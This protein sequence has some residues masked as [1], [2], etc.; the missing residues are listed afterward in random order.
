M[1]KLLQ[2]LFVFLFIAFSAMAQDRTITGTVTSQEDGL[3]LP[4]VS[5]KALGSAGGT[6]TDGNG[7]YSIKVSSANSLQF[8]YLGHVSKTLSIPSSGLLNLSLVPDANT[9]QDINIVQVAYGTQR[10]QDVVGSL[11]TVSASQLQKQQVTSVTQGLQGLATGVLVINGSGQPGTNPTIRIRGVASVNASAEPLIVLDGLA[12]SGSINSIGPNDVESMTVLKDAAATSLYGSRAANGVILITTKRGKNGDAA[13]NAY[14]NYGVSSRAVDEY[15]YVSSEDY[16][17]LAWEAQKNYAIGLNIPNPG[18]YASTNLITGTANTYG[19]KYNPYNVANP[20]DANGNLVPGASLLWDTDWAK[21]GSNP[22]VR[23]KN[24]GLNIQG[25]SDKFRYFLSTDYLDQDGTVKNSNYNRLTTRFNGDANLRSWLKVGL[26]SSLAASKNNNPS[27]AGSAFSNAVQFARIVSSIYPLYRRDNNGA[28][29]LD[30]T[31]APIYDFGGSVA[32]QT[33]NSGRP[34]ASNT[35]AVALQQ[36]DKNTS[37]TIQSSLNAYAEVA[38]TD[39]LKFKSNVGI[40]RN[41]GSTLVYANPL[42]G[43]AAPVGG[44]VTRG[45]NLLT[46]WTWNNMLSFDK[47]FGKHRLGVIASTEAYDYKSET[48]SAGTT[49]FPAPGLYE[50]SP[51]STKETATSGTVRRRIESYFARAS[52][53]YDSKYFLEGSVRRDGST[54]FAADK[55]WGTFYSVGGSYVISNESFMANQK[56]FDYLKIRASYGEIGNE[57][58]SSSFPYISSYSTLYPDL[59]NPG[60]YL[61][62]LGNPDVT[63]EK[64]GTFNVGLDFAVL[65]NRISASIEYYNK[66]TFDLLFSRP[67]PNSS[68]FTAIDDNVGKIKN[69]GFEFTVDS[70]NLTGAFKWS[71]NINVATLKNRI[72]A[73]PQNF[74]ISGTKRLEVGVPLYDFYTYEWAG[75]N[76]D[77]GKPQW[78]ADDPNNPGGTIIVNAIATARRSLQGSA[79]PKV[80]GGITNTFEYKG[81]DLSALFNF[82]LGG[83]ILDSD[84]ISLMHGFSNV[85]AALSTDILNRWTTPGQVTDVPALK[86]GNSDYGSASTRHLFKGDYLRLRNVTLGY[87]LPQSVIAKSRNILKSMRFYVQG[88]NFW[89]LS[90]LKKGADPETSIDGVTSQSSATFKTFTFGLNVGF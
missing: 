18:Q 69:Q 70:K 20:I 36:L 41:V 68:G 53:N 87:T 29:V 27:Q 72:T 79:L 88:D 49:G 43:D 24:V 78:Y 52:Y 63:W 31:G 85:G 66:N 13:I 81:F 39:Y 65:K 10:K 32:G 9:L 77:N 57:G 56:V 58:L 76:P 73:L 30:A 74:I 8:S 45:R 75:V 42:L 21:E 23:R 2:S 35:N 3:P 19:L 44:R 6:Q 59:T 47:S 46:D 84:Y 5:V 33:Y 34:A 83:K 90:K 7:K 28:L 86:F 25:G 82:S 1:K 14:A 40:N 55:R 60:V 50:V 37:E 64:Q 38:F 12:Y 48:L 22:S 61:T 4:G 62:T 67:L 80:T 89:T 17:K 71:T 15:K 54:R 51:G 11:T 16:M 26:N